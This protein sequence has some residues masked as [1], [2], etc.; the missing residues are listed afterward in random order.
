MEKAVTFG[1]HHTLVGIVS[2]PSSPPQQPPPALLLLNANVLHRVGPNRLYVDLARRFSAQGVYALR[3]DL[4]GVGD[5]PPRKDD[6][7]YTQRAISEIRQAMDYMAAHYGCTRFIVAGLCAGADSGYNTAL[8]DPRITGLVLLDGYG[9]RNPGYYLHH[10]LPRTVQLQVWRNLVRRIGKKIFRKTATGHEANQPSAQQ[11]DT[12]YEGVR[13]FPTKS[14][15]TQDL[16]TLIQRHTQLLWIYTG[17][18]E[19]YYNYEKQFRDSYK[20][21][22]RDAHVQVHLF[23]DAEHTYTSPAHREHAI[24]TILAWYRNKFPA[25][26]EATAIAHHR[27]HNQTYPTKQQAAR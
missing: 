20:I 9:H 6:E 25:P 27:D 21:A 23:K 14:Q 4:S 7:S 8:H 17:G 11:I 16:N 24:D 12:F 22:D 3:F 15:M 2:E 19:N 10:Y 26:V 5:S 1:Q 18:V 13:A